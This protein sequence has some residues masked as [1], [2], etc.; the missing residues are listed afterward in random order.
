MYSKNLLTEIIKAM[1]LTKMA[2]HISLFLDILC[3]IK[4]ETS[5]D[6]SKYIL[7]ECLEY[8]F[9]VSD[10]VNVEEVDHRKS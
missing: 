7:K 8:L 5:D 2:L 4:G 1:I 3:E 9:S 6:S 10:R